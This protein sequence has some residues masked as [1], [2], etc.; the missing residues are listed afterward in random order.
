MPIGEIILH[1]GMHKT[2]TTSIQKA[3]DGYDDGQIAYANLQIPR[4]KT[5]NHGVAIETIF[6]ADFENIPHHVGHGR[7]KSVIAG[8][9]PQFRARLVQQLGLTRERLI[10]S[11]EAMQRLRPDELT[12]LQA[13]LSAHSQRVTVL[14]YIREP[15]GFCSSMFQQHCKSATFLAPGKIPTPRY[16]KK[17]EKFI[18]VFGADNVRFVHYDPKTLVGGSSVDDFAAQTGIPKVPQRQSANQGLS[19]DATKCLYILGQDPRLNLQRLDARMT[20]LRLLDVL[21]SG[22]PGTSF[23]LPLDSVTK[24]VDPADIAWMEKTTGFA[25]ALPKPARQETTNLHQALQTLSP[26]G[27]AQLRTI[28]SERRRPSSSNDSVPEMMYSLFELHRGTVGLRARA[29][30]IYDHGLALTGRLWPR[31]S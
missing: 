18:K 24:R 25:L 29:K 19:T 27:E 28:L 26:D 8:F 11:G 2:G 16:R 10:I 6:R 9:R 31:G 20:F 3:F 23:R 13:L 22:M 17:F 30:R 5:P 1:V 21:K 12:A 7:S 4:N 15:H 14:A